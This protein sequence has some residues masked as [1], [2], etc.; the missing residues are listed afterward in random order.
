[1]NMTSREEDLLL[2]QL[3]TLIEW[4]AAVFYE[5]NEIEFTKKEKEF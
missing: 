5:G 2:C 3:K 1:M 4:K